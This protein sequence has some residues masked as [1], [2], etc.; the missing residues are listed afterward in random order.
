MHSIHLTI[1]GLK[2]NIQTWGD[3]VRPPLF[4]FHGWMD[5]GASFD[6]LCRHLE[7]DYYCIAPDFR[8]MGHSEHTPDPLGYFYV[9]YI[10]DIH[11]LFRHFSPEQSVRVLGHSM[12]GNVVALYAGAYPDRVSHFINIEGFGIFDMPAEMGPQRMRQ[13]I[14]ELG[15]KSF[16]IYKTLDALAARLRESN[17]HLTTER[18]LFL[19]KHLSRQVDGGFQITA[20]PKHKYVNPYL[21]QLNNVYPF[22]R[23][24]EAKCLLISAEHTNMQHWITEDQDFKAEMARRLKHF[25]AEAQ[26]IE[27]PGAGHM[28]H[29]DQP[30]ELAKHVRIFLQG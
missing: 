27:I 24:I 20:D 1:N 5:M 6:F 13:W 23:R 4:L 8:G 21:F 14:D 25:P 15:T 18:S 7:N 11:A 2:H 26:Y 10:A 17:R 19:A 30:E 22:W 3:P 16:Q 9:E 12:G 29:H 28:V